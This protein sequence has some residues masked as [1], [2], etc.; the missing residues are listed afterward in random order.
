MKKLIGFFEESEGNK[1][2]TRLLV[3]MLIAYA[4]L[5]SA[6]VTIVGLVNY[7]RPHS[8]ETLG[9]IVTSAG[10]LLCSISAF[11]GG[12]KLIQKPMENNESPNI[13]N[14]PE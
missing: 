5:I 3:F 10:S 2:M 1:S 6:G 14:K 8:T 7:L 4:I 11:A 9:S 13:T 12:W